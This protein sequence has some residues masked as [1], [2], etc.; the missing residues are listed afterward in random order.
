MYERFTD[1]ARKVM[2]LANKEALRSKHAQVDSGHVLCALVAEGSGVAANIL[3]NFHVD[4]VK[5][6]RH[7][8]T[9]V[10]P[11]AT[12]V[13]MAELP[14]TAD[15]RTLIEHSLDEAGKLSHNYVGTEHL[16]LGLVRNPDGVGSRVLVNLG[17][18]LADVRQAVLDLL[19]HGAG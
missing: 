9:I 15:S 6:R 13:P 12:P 8:E 1:R 18:K 2:H 5:I 17:L 16:L 3:K 7:A 19:G 14:L 10:P 11:G 4:P